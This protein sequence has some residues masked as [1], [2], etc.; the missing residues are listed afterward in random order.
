MYDATLLNPT[1]YTVFNSKRY[2]LSDND[3]PL[4]FETMVFGGKYANDMR[5]YSTW[6]QAK[7]GHERMVEKVKKG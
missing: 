2:Q 1:G 5:R 4:L 7:E 6:K 3:P